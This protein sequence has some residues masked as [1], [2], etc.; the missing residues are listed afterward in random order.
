MCHLVFTEGKKTSFQWPLD[1]LFCATNAVETVDNLLR[2]LFIMSRLN[3]YL[4][5]STVWKS[6]ADMA[7]G[8]VDE[9]ANF[10][11]HLSF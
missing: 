4:I 1:H 6:T 11:L 2:D 7:Q 5:M 10:Y 8:A 9:A 3:I